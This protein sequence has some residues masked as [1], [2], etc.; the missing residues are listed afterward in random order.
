MAGTQVSIVINLGAPRSPGG[1]F[2]VLYPDG[3][4]LDDFIQDESVGVHVEGK[5]WECAASFQATRAVLTWPLDA[6]R[7]IPA[8]VYAITLRTCCVPQ[9][10]VPKGPDPASITFNAAGDST[11]GT[12]QP[13]TTMTVSAADGTELGSGAV[14]NDGTFTIALSPAVSEGDVVTFVASNDRGLES[15]PVEVTATLG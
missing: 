7:D 15:D 2:G 14:A 11:S 5:T 1:T 6:P 12:G 3:M 4:I 8:G 9:F 10:S 13:S